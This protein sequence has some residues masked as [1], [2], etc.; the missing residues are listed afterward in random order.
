MKA[1]DLVEEYYL[2][3][4]AFRHQLVYYFRV[5]HALL[6]FQLDH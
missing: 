3:S 5:F 1:T 4:N 6:L 2:Q